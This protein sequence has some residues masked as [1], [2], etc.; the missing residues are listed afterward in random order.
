V[1]CLA[2]KALLPPKRRIWCKSAVAWAQE[3]SG[4]PGM[5]RH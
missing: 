4:I 5:E 3:V 1:G 2:Q